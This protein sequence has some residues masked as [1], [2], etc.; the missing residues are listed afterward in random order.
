M[1]FPLMPFIA[2]I[3]T[4]SRAQAASYLFT[5]F[6]TLMTGADRLSDTSNTFKTR[7][8]RADR[9][10]NELTS[11]LGIFN[12]SP[13]APTGGQLSGSTLLFMGG[14]DG[15][16]ADISGAQVNG[17]AAALTNVFNVAAVSG[18]AIRHSLYY[19]TSTLRPNQITTARANFPV[20][21]GSDIL[22]ASAIYILPGG[23]TP[24]T[25]ANNAGDGSAVT[26]SV[27][28]N[29]LVVYSIGNTVDSSA[30]N[31]TYTAGTLIGCSKI[32]WYD[33][34]EHGIVYRTT[35][36]NITLT[37]TATATGGILRLTKFTYG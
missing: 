21:S 9:I 27:L 30:A 18:G 5:N 4:L 15:T 22:N 35:D 13:P 24:S 34:V 36:G 6:A 7:T 23:W 12:T 3:S 25:Q 8:V 10:G 14:R 11:S 1:T 28:A 17:V 37:P 29:E 16:N 26:L 2:P 19:H 20:G 33:G 31:V 32:N